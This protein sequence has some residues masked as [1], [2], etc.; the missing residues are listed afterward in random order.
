MFKVIGIISTIAIAC[1]IVFHI[2]IRIVNEFR[3]KPIL[4]VKRVTVFSKTDG[5]N[6]LPSLLIQLTCK[7]YV[8]IT[9][10]FLLWEYY[11][12]YSFVYEEE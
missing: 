3:D 9:F 1:W 5:F 8:E 2:V 7:K 6:V 12:C 4:E 10:S 11:M